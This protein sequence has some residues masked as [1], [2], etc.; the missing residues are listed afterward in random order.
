MTEREAPRRSFAEFFAAEIAPGLPVLEAQ[1]RDRRRNAYARLFGATFVVVVAA[2]IAAML[3][4]PFVGGA[5]LIVGAVAGLLWSRQP[6]RRHRLAVRE[7]VIP[8]LLRF[9]GEV[10]HHRKP[11]RRF[12]LDRIRRRGIAGAF[13]R[14]KLEAL[15]S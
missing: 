13:P 14:E 5:V 1:R 7:L 8:P 6:A 9:L 3:W 12:D 2:L 15:R 4:H 11:G 10:E